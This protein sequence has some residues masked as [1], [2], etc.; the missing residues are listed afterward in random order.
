MLKLPELSPDPRVARF[1]M[2]LW[3][4]AWKVEELSRER[5]RSR[6]SVEEQQPAGRWSW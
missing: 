6:L 4:Y 3:Q 5:D 2:L 1:Q